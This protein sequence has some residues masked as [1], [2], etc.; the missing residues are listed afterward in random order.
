MDSGA[1]HHITTD[2]ANLS[3]HEPYGSTDGVI[4]G[5]D[6]KLPIS[7][8]GTLSF[9]ESGSLTF[10]DVLLIPFMAKNLLSVSQ[11]CNQNNVVVCFSDVDFQVKDKCSGRC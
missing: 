11:L 5:N 8:I 1:S 7:H 9:L 10:H 4:V 3:L 2:L 6:N